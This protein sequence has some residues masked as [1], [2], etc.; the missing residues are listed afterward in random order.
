MIGDNTAVNGDN[1]T[2]LAHRTY[3]SRQYPNKPDWTYDSIDAARLDLASQ[4]AYDLVA[5]TERATRSTSPGWP[6]GTPAPPTSPTS[7]RPPTSP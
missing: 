7:S 4:V 3:T 2:A 6:R 1:L 5:R